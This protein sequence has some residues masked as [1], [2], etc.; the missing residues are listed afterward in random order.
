MRS[1]N[2][3]YVVRGV[4][5]LV[6]LVHASAC[7]SS[8]GAAISQD[9]AAET[10]D[11]RVSDVPLSHTDAARADAAAGNADLAQTD[12]VADKA[13]LARTDAVADKADLARTDAPSSSADAA[14]AEAS[15]GSAGEAGSATC[16]PSNGGLRALWQLPAVTINSLAADPADSIVVAGSFTDTVTFGSTSLV[17]A[18]Q[19]DMFLAKYDSTGAVLWARRF[20]TANIDGEIRATAID[21]SGNVYIAGFFSYTLDFGDGTAPLVPIGLDAF[22]AKLTGDSHTLWAERFGYSDGTYAVESLAIGP[23]GELVIAGTSRGAILLGNQLWT[24]QEGPT[25]PNQPFV[26][27]LHAADGSVLW[28]AAAGGDF[29]IETIHVAVDASGRVFLAGEADSG[30]GAWGKV[31]DA[32]VGYFC[33]FRAGFDPSGKP[34]WSRFDGNG[35]PSGI[36]VDAAGRLSVFEYGGVEP[37]IV[38]DKTIDTQN[39]S[40]ALLLSPIDGSL[41]SS[42]RL[43]GVFAWNVTTDGRGNSLL[44]GS[45]SGSIS[46]GSTTLPSPGPAGTAEAVVLAAADGI[47]QVRAAFSLGTTGGSA[48]PAAITVAPSQRIVIAAKTDKALT[49]AVGT[50]QPGSFLALYDPAPCSLDTG[51]DGNGTGNPAD[52]GDLPASGT[53]YQPSTVQPAACPTKQAGATS[54]A[55]CPV[56]MGCSYGTTCCFCKPSPCNGQTT[57]WTC[58]DLGVIDSNCP[59][60]PPAAGTACV[61]GTECHY[62]LAGGLYYARCTAGGWGTGYS[63]LLCI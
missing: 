3:Y 44:A 30:A 2:V 60:S 59:L 41:I 48:I 26:A 31:P 40:L 45:Y 16:P 39:G 11:S 43:P 54:G 29:A 35:T 56:A 27:K 52:H 38:G 17:S 62:C 61:A 18:G 42:L 57:L 12:A 25:P 37:I 58:D 19:D 33:T 63:Q 1:S 28:S 5:L 6:G 8:S 13:D 15:D 51:P 36:S 14:G 20:G 46:V 53:A 9:D 50:A 10:S 32:L 49:T 24:N 23:D 4:L 34:L 7:K 55:A 47:P 22:V 21:T